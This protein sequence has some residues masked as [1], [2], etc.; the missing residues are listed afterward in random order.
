MGERMEEV[1]LAYGFFCHLM[2]QASVQQLAVT[3]GEVK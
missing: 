3:T 2:A 1:N